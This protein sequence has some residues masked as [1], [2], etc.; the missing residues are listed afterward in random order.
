M[1]SASAA[2]GGRLLKLGLVKD[3]IR[4]FEKGLAKDAA[5]ES[6]LLGLMRAH[7]SLEHPDAARAAINRMLS[8]YPDNSEAQSHLAM[9]DAQGGDKAALKKLEALSLA[10]KAGFFE[11][12]N[13][14]NLLQAKGDLA[15][16]E[17]AFLRAAQ[18]APDN[19]FVQVELGQ[20][21]MGKQNV[22]A[23]LNHFARAVELMPNEWVPAQLLARALA[24][25]GQLGQAVAALNRAVAQAPD[26]PSLYDDLF[27]F[28]MLAGS[29]QGAVKAAMELRRLKPNDANPI[30]LHG[31]ATLTLGEVAGAQKLFEAALELAPSSWEV[32]QA[33]AKA[34][35]LLKNDKKAQA[36]LVEA[37]TA[38]P[39]APG[40][41][42]DLALLYLEQ[43]NGAAKAQKVLE[44]VLK[45]APGD[46]GTHLN[47][48]L[49]LVQLG[50]KREA[51]PHVE[52]AKASPD[53]DVREQALRLQKQLG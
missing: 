2:D 47:L 22:K 10:P 26:Q 51:A 20:L 27:K 5:D 9:L 44:R 50:K 1:V 17:K 37:N 45:A 42:N 14:A 8:K 23:A 29:V 28:C 13:L 11:H 6:C 16:A 21:A 31:L 53:K 32:K 35:R 40:P 15:G 4:E 36:L 34:L 48:A 43:T 24:L 52:K 33:L 18:A 3:A 30:Y 49:T 12:Y 19:P 38:A 25:D 7:L 41:A 39:D 46:F